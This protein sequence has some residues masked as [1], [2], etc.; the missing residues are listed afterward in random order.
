MFLF[1]GVCLLVSGFFLC[2]CPTIVQQ[3]QHCQTQKGIRRQRCRLLLDRMRKMS[4]EEL[5]HPLP[6]RHWILGLF[7]VVSLHHKNSSTKY[8]CFLV[9]YDTIWRE[10]IWMRL[11]QTGPCWAASAGHNWPAA[12]SCAT[13]W[14]LRSG[15]GMATASE[16][17]IPSGKLTCRHQDRHIP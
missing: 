4:K 7:L 3:T 15:D 14:R 13:G 9:I 11:T 16:G 6:L 8:L 17:Q 1:G 2:S 12:H 10:S 5:F